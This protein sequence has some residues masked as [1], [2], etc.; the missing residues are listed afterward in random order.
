MNI[1]EHIEAGHYERDEK[2]RALVP[3]KCGKVAIIYASDYV[4]RWPIVGTIGWGRPSLWLETGEGEGNMSTD[5]FLLPPPPR[6]VKVRKWI[7]F[8]ERDQMTYP[9]GGQI[10]PAGCFDKS[11]HAEAFAARRAGYKVVELHGEYEEPVA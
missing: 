2:G 6:K 5:W 8:N 9:M 11:E 1:K 3:M 10:A 7:V 4:G